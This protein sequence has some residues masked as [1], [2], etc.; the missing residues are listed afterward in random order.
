LNNNIIGIAP[1]NAVV[2][3]Y[4]LGMTTGTAITAAIKPA[5]N[6][7]NPKINNALFSINHDQ[8]QQ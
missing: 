8:Q 2:E 3:S 6:I 4:G 7:N 1:V 5:N